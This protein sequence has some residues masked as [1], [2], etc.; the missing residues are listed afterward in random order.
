M[1]TKFIKGSSGGG[2]S[3][4]NDLSDVTYTD[5][6]LRITSLDK[7]ASGALTIESTDKIVLDADDM[8]LAKGI[9]FD[10]DG[11]TVAQIS[12]H[13]SATHLNLYENGG[14]SDDDFLN[15]KC[16][17]NGA[18]TIAT[19]DAAGTDADLT[20]DIDGDI[21]LDAATGNI[22]VKDN[23][24]NYTPGSDYEIA[25]KKYVDD[26][27]AKFTV[28]ESNISYRMTSVNNYYVASNSLGTSIAA[29]DFGVS[30]SRY[31]YYYA[32]ADKVLTRWSFVGYVSSVEPYEF[33]LW[34][35]TVASDGG[36]SASAATQVGS[37]LS[38][39][40]GGGN[41]SNSRFYTVQS[42]V[43]SY[44][45]SAGH[46]LYLVMRYTDGSGTKTVTGTL[47]MEFKGV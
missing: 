43:L 42:G 32:N 15:L 45:V 12:V 20:L 34:D 10:D 4:L 17:A 5:G 8:T 28:H 29:A 46:Q 36:V 47:S 3:E 40:S 6:D 31:A 9:R 38:M 7:I 14:A 18:S 21:T 24:G 19:T 35:V 25:T 30:E 1:G 11:T 39:P 44:T 33:E 27:L 37:T 23:G 22:Y 13:H 16:E 26:I 2:A 41:A